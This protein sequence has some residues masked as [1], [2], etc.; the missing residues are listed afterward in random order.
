[1][2]RSIVQYIDSVRLLIQYGCTATVLY[3]RTL[4]ILFYI[5]N[6]SSK[7]FYSAPKFIYI[8]V[9]LYQTMFI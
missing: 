9:Y 1:M 8:L 2:N 3:K 6:S 5:T 7:L 4:G